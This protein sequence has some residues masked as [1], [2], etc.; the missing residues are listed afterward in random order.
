MQTSNAL[1]PAQEKWLAPHIIDALAE[2]CATGLWE[3]KI[4]CATIIIILH[5]PSNRCPVT[6]RHHQ[7]WENELAKL[8][9]V[10]VETKYDL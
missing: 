1:Y 5:R 4:D 3:L 6:D 10:I 2:Y 9:N 7:L 8:L